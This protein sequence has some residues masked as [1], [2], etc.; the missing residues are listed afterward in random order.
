VRSHRASPSLGGGE[1]E[2]PRTPQEHAVWNLL[3]EW[4]H[5]NQ[6]VELSQALDLPALVDNDANLSALE[7][8][9]FGAAKGMRHLI[10][11]KL[12]PDLGAGVIANGALTPACT[13]PPASSVTCTTTSKG[14]LRLRSRGC[15]NQTV[16]ITRVMEQ[17]H[18]AYPDLL[19][20]CDIAELASVANATSAGVSPGRGGTEEALTMSP[21]LDS[22]GCVVSCWRSVRSRR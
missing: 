3:P 20:I 12:V 9:H 7:E 1:G 11:M 4:A 15:L 21:Q 8:A 2:S 16:K 18:P 17:L 10:Y 14:P 19:T 5:H 13:G 22:P 6:G